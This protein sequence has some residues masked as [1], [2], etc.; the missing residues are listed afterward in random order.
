[1]GKQRQ[2][3]MCIKF[4]VVDRDCNA[5]I[6]Y[7]EIEGRK[8]IR[9][10]NIFYYNSPRIPA[11]PY[12]ELLLNEIRG[13]TF[14]YPEKNDFFI[15][16]ALIY[17]YFFPEEMHERA[18][19]MSKQFFNVFEVVYPK[20]KMSKKEAIYML[21]NS[22][23]LFSN[24]RKFAEAIVNVRE[25][26][27][28]KPLYAV[29]IAN[30]VNLPILIY[31]GIDFFDCLDIIIKSRKGIYFTSEKEYR[32]EEIEEYPCGCEFCRKGIDDFHALL[33]H[34]Y[35]VMKNELIKIIYEIK[36][37]NLREYVEAKC[38]FNPNLASILRLLDMEYH[39]FQEKRYAIVGG[40]IV[41]SP[42]SLNRPDIKRF[43]ERVIKRY[44]KPPSTKI[45]LLLPCSAKKPYSK[46]KSHLLFNRV[47]SECKNRHVIHEVIL[48]SPLGIVPRELEYTYPAAHYD[49]SVIGY[50]DKEEIEMINR[51]LNEYLKRNGYD[52]IINHMPPNISNFLEIDA[53]NT[54]IDNPIS[55]DSLKKLS[56][57]IKIADDYE[58]VRHTKRR[59]ENAKSIL[60]YQFG[61]IADEF[62]NGCEVK[63]KF[64]DYKIYFED[65]QLAAFVEKRGLFSLT[66]AGGKKLGKNYYIEID[67]FIP[68]GSVFAA[69][70]KNADERIRREDEVTIYFN[71]ELRGVGIAKM[72]AEEMVESKNGLAVKVRHYR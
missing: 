5:R 30:P 51:C 63:G 23:E 7:I 44:R 6:G 67:D 68:K 53:I 57:A 38:H 16:P 20:V 61:E 40:K 43:R 22:R 65:K 39:E 10:P 14:F 52:I 69:G 56:Q 42:Y 32:I 55:N 4:E 19:E 11:P 27:G 9:F 24:P 54:C 46:S 13:G 71:N 62:L 21:A 70:V 59:Y 18:F 15:P 47:I 60:Y 25:K 36:N 33:M 48:T 1:M 72:N 29:G 58:R 50:W 35:E 28:Y 41:S 17:P 49:I 31:C 66:F 37:K 2:N 45:L 8:K 34:N 12:A 64:P 3:E 26:I